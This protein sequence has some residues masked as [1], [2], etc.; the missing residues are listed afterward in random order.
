MPPKSM[1]SIL[2][3]H[4]ITHAAAA[5]LLQLQAMLTQRESAY[6]ALLETVQDLF[7]QHSLPPNGAGADPG[8][9]Q[10]EGMQAAAAGWLRWFFG[11]RTP[12]LASKDYRW[13]SCTLLHPCSLC[14]LAC[15]HC[16]CLMSCSGAMP[17]LAASLCRP[18]CN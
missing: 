12:L 9:A 3:T 6:L 17:E 13:K 5:P 16:P 15:R 18:A 11:T 7:K 4:K 1:P 10:A 2:C 8:P 14:P